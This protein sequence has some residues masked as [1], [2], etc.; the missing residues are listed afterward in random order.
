MLE[1]ALK[2]QIAYPLRQLNLKHKIHVYEKNITKYVQ[3]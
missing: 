1:Y 3:Y 2:N